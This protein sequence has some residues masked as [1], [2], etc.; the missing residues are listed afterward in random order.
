MT[1]ITAL[2]AVPN[3][4]VPATFN[5]DADAFL[6]ALPTFRTELNIV[7][8]EVV[9]N[10]DTT[11]TNVTL[12]VTYKNEAQAAAATAVGAAGAAKWL[13]GTSYDEGD[14]TWSPVNYQ[15]YRRNGV[16]TPPVAGGADPSSNPDWWI[17]ITITIPAQVLFSLG[18]I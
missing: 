7:A 14:T 1:T 10:R 16:G 3:S 6:G 15:S 13:V 17:P 11:D 2:P 5:A 12:T 8:T 18:V 9:N 4:A